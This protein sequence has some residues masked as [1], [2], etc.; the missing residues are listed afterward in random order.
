ME[1]L[2]CQRLYN[3]LSMEYRTL[4]KTGL[5]VSSLGFG[6]G[7]VGGL[8]VRGDQA[9]M[10]RAVA[11]AIELGV[12]YFD[13]AASYGDGA[14][15]ENLGRILAEL[16]AEVIVATKTRL[17]AADLDALEAAIIASVDA[18]LRRLRRDRIDV[19]QLHTPLGL[20]RDAAAQRADP[21]DFDAAMSAF[22]RLQAQGKIGHWGFTGLGDTAALHRA[23]AGHAQ[24][25]QCCY[26]LLNPTAGSEAPPDFPFQDYGRLIDRAS[27]RGLGV[28]AIR[29]LAAG[30]LSGST[31]RHP[32]AMP[33]VDPIG[34][35]ETL[36][37]DAARAGRFG[38]LVEEGHA[39]SLAEAAIRFAI[40]HP[41]VST[42]LIGISTLTQLEAAVAAANRG[43]LP[44]SAVA[45]L[46][47]V[48][49]DLAGAGSPQP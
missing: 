21:A 31:D 26:N 38:F 11:R 25:V 23:V 9:E 46:G 49:A 2:A 1:S 22:A 5:R 6:C 7:A 15:E 4:G 14:S 41:G 32:N 20:T 12:N 33:Q 18:S 28:I 48:W 3:P 8:L 16:G 19:I 29:I 42:A 39:A 10:A 45:R 34:T 36:A 37:A 35:G 44:A 40:D 30:A 47:P 17:R 43:P 13:T 27:A 24:T